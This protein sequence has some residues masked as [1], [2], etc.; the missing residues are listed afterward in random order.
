LN[1]ICEKCN[2]VCNS[3][4]FQR[5]FN[6]WT[7]SNKNI[8]KFIQIT[9]LSDHEYYKYQ[10]LEWIPY[11]RLHDIIHVAESK[12]SKIYRANWIDGCINKWDY[13]DQNWI[14]NKPN[15]FVILK[16]LNNSTDTSIS[17]FINKV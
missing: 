17:K 5:N 14:R 16:I 13:D 3:I 2:C 6:N 1:D 10:A 12:S 15:M 11:N 8:D 4:H 7:S 9:Q